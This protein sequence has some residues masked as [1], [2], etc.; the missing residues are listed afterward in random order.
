MCDFSGRLI[1]WLDHELPEDEAA[2]VERHVRVCT[3]CQSRVDT[4]K[5]V[6][7]AFDAYCEAVVASKM[8]RR[9]S[10]WASVLSGV[11]ASVA[12]V[13]FLAF[14]RAPV[15]QLPLRPPAAAASP[16]IVLKTTPSPI[17]RRQR[18]PVAPVQSQ[19]ANWVPAEPAIQIAIPAEA[20]F[21]PGAIPEGV[22]FIADVSI[23]TDGS[24]QRLR[25]R[26]RL[27]GLERRPT[28]P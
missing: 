4:Y 15:Q 7:S 21:P 12:A 24:A 22:N 14:P 9:L 3:E 1:A 11:A 10:L 5:E 25:L 17:K 13:L 26:P 28:Q 6:G 23:A 20:I 27:V 18:R 19:N 8:R 2:D 16:A